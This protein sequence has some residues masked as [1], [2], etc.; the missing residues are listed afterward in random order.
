LIPRKVDHVARASLLPIF[1]V[2]R[3]ILKIL[4]VSRP[5]LILETGFS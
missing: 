5:A 3:L 2:H 1:F 4:K